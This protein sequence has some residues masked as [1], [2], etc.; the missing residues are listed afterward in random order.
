MTEYEIEYRIRIVSGNVP[1]LSRM[2]EGVPLMFDSSNDAITYR[3]N[4]DKQLGAIKRRL[5]EGNEARRFVIQT[6]AGEIAV[7]RYGAVEGGV[8]RSGAATRF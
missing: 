1:T 6:S 7:Y 8:V 4:K 5:A 2:V 3:V